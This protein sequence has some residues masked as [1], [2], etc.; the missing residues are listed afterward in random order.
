[1]EETALKRNIPVNNLIFFFI[2][3]LTGIFNSVPLH[4]LQHAK[5]TQ[6]NQITEIKIIKPN[7]RSV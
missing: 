2:S 5:W 1:M 3:K 6:I 4:S 7:M